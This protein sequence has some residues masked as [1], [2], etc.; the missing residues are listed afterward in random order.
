VIEQQKFLDKQLG[1][2][3]EFNKLFCKLSVSPSDGVKAILRTGA[4]RF[5][6]EPVY[7][8]TVLTYDSIWRWLEKF[9]QKA[10][11]TDKGV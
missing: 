6:V 4:N 7:F 3:S 10:N 1:E 5:D 11:L 8:S 2:L 9:S